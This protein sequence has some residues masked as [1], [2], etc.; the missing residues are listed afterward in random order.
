ML[1]HS[2]GGAATALREFNAQVIEAVPA[3]TGSG[4]EQTP[5]FDVSLVEITDIDKVGELWTDLQA[6]SRHSFFTSWGWIGCWLKQMP[7]ACRPSLLMARSETGVAGLGV[8]NRKRTYRGKVIHS[9][10]LFLHATGEEAYDSLTIEHNAFLAETRVEDEVQRAFLTYLCETCPDWDELHLNG[11]D[12]GGNLAQLVREAGRGVQFRVTRKKPCYVVDLA[13]LRDSGKDYVSTLGHSTRRH[14]RQTLRTYAASG[15]VTTTAARDVEEALRFLEELKILHRATW[16][17][18]GQGGA[19]TD[20]G[21]NAF[22]R[23]LIETRF[24]HGEIQLLKFQAGEQTIGYLYNFA[25]NG[26]V[27]AYQSAFQYSE[28]ERMKPGYVCHTLA[29]EF[30]LAQGLQTYDFLAGDGQYKK[31]LGRG[32]REMLWGTLQRDRLRFRVEDLL[33]YVQRRMRS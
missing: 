33:R 27:C 5:R 3:A 25:Q 29:I 18:R 17:A 13:A 28:L 16:E 24:R 11:I 31:S 4:K 10:G 6:R 23:R 19:F 2:H 22:H 21:V 1:R 20:P 14:I 30:N 9:Q 32:D 8:L 12:A 7:A 15:P 26:H